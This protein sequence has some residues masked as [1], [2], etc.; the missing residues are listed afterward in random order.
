MERL[1]MDR[2]VDL[3][4]VSSSAWAVVSLVLANLVPLVGVLFFGWDLWTIIALYWAENGI[5]GLYN[6]AKILKA[7]G[8]SPVMARLGRAPLSGA[9]QAAVGVAS[10]VATAAFFVV[11]YGLF[12]FV[13]GMFVLVFLPSFAGIRGNG[14]GPEPGFDPGFG[15]PGGALLGVRAD[16]DLV[17]LGAAA[18]AVSHG[19]AFV[20]DFLARKEYRNVSPQAQAGAPYGRLVI[21]HLTIILGALLSAALGVPIGALL[22]LVALKIALDLALHLREHRAPAGAAAGP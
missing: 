3:Y 10:R 1:S 21:L 14:G 7:E 5:I 16:L 20:F 13:H 19:I 6:V 12:W 2:L 4:R 22:V 9:Q 15:V 18:L 17:I 8:T 11:H